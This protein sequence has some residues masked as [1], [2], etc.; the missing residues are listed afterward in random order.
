MKN[1]KYAFTMIEMVFVIVVLG[2]LSAIAIPKFAA[3]RTD[4]EV[5]KGRADIASVRSGIVTE[6]QTRLITG[7]SDYISGINLNTGTGVFGGVLMY[8]VTTSNA[9]GHWR[10]AGVDSNASSAYIYRV[11]GSDCDFT[12]TRNDGKFVL[13]ASQDAICDNLVD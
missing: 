13:D 9:N 7:G 6:R 4:A 12:Y 2:I 11:G 1:S 8:P 5:S 10:S 3:T